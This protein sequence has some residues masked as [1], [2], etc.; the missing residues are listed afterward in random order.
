[1]PAAWTATPP[2]P[3][4]EPRTTPRSIW[5]GGEVTRVGGKGPGR[6]FVVAARG[7]KVHPTTPAPTRPRSA[8]GRLSRGRRMLVTPE[9]L[10]ARASQLPDD[11]DPQETAEWLESLEAVIRHQGPDRARF[12]LDTLLSVAAKAGAKM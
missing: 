4:S 11:I 6:G 1:M 2:R 8:G 7:T 3:R 12:L 5:A 9:V 10:A